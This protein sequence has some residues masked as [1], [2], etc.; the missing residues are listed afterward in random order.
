MKKKLLETLQKLSTLQRQDILR[1]AAEARVT[2]Q[3]AEEHTAELTR[4]LCQTAPDFNKDLHLGREAAHYARI[5]QLKITE[6]NKKI[7]HHRT[8][9]DNIQS[10][11]T[12]HARE[13]ENIR[14]LS[15]RE[16]EKRRKER[17][18][19]AEKTAE[20]FTLFHHYSHRL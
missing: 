11:L 20:N 4:R 13:E 2:L 17:Q 1:Q 14:L 5:L 10:Q 15:N 9:L 3:N 19:R 18:D 6:N 12:D 7:T 8:T 16:A